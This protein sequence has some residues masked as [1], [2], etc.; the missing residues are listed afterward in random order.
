LLET[1]TESEVVD[2][3]FNAR[4]YSKVII[5]VDAEVCLNQMEGLLIDFDVFMTLEIFDFVQT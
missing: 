1:D 3:R 4:S 2:V 5:V